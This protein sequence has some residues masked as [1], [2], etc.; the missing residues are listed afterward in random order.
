MEKL[1]EIVFSAKSPYPSLE[2]KEKNC[3]YAGMMLDNMGGS[4]S[5]LS[6]VSLYL[7]NHLIADAEY[8]EISYIFHKISI[9]EMHHLEIFGKLALLNG[10]NPRLWTRSRR[11][12]AYWTPGYNKYPTTLAG[13]ME[14]ALKGEYAAVR[15]YQEQLS[16][17]NDACIAAVLQRIIEDENIHIELF[18]QI[19]SEYRL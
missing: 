7:Y 9:V 3:R 18:R 15:K 8:E 12:R 1:Q 13:L 10:E 14:N 17:V 4:N 11:G 2:V 19:I 6:A 16:Y 5:E